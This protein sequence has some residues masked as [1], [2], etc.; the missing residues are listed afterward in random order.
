MCNKV[1]HFNK[2]L[3]PWFLAIPE[4]LKEYK[5]DQFLVNTFVVVFAFYDH[6]GRLGQLQIKEGAFFLG[7]SV[8]K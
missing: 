5:S 6:L 4:I 8:Y 2:N 7:H 3:T 1:Y